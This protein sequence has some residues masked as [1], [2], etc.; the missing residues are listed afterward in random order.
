MKKIISLLGALALVLSFSFA[1]YAAENDVD[2]KINNVEACTTYQDVLDRLN[3]EYGTDVHFPSA[4]EREKYGIPVV[5]IDVS[6]EEFE[7]QMRKDIEANLRA[8]AEAKAAAQKLNT[9]Q[10]I[11]S[12]SGICT[13]P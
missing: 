4:E 6:L 10:I 3:K 1:A 11:E 9:E 12:G 13:K 7:A 5:E 2:L 8:N